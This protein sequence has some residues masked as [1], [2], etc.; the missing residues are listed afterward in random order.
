M[1]KQT[2]RLISPDVRAY[3]CD[4]ILDAENGCSVVIAPPGMVV[5]VEEPK[6]T[7][8]QNSKQHAMYKDIAD[9]CDFMGQ[10][11]HPDD[12]KRV[13]NDAFWRAT[14]DDPEYMESWAKTQKPRIVPSLDGTGFVQLGPQSSRYDT[15]LGAGLI[16]FM[17]AW[18]SAQGVRWRYAE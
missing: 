18:G 9:H 4:K 5:K 3:C 8:P 13:L 12:W 6:R 16:E 15:K 17:Y 11:M 7:I 10:R 1:N 14:K 2:F